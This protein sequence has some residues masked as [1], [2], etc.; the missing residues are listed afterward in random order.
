MTK[1]VIHDK[2][3][4]KCIYFDMDDSI[5]GRGLCKKT[6]PQMNSYNGG[7]EWARVKYNDWCYG[8]GFNPLWEKRI[9]K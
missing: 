5:E 9:K 3:C 6:P 2:A 8:H 7:G 1:I 4:I